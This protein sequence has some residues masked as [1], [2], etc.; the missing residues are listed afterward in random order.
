MSESNI[1]IIE[2]EDTLQLYASILPEE[3][4]VKTVTWS[5]SDEEVATISESG[6]VTALAVSGSGVILSATSVAGQTIK[7][8]FT[9][10]IDPLSPNSITVPS[11]GHKPTL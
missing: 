3:A 8:D 6:L 11:P 1:M 5:S 2:V 4:E 10:Y 9:L 7:G